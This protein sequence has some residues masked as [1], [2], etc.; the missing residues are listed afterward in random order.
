MIYTYLH[1]NETVVFYAGCG[2]ERRSRNYSKRSLLWKQVAV[3]G[4][5]VLT[6]GEFENRQDAWEHEKELIAY[7]KPHCNKALGGPGSRGVTHSEET[8]RNMSLSKIG[9]LNP[10]SGRTGETNPCYGRQHSA[11]SKLLMSLAKTGK[12]HPQYGKHLPNE[13]KAKISMAHKEKVLSN[14]HKLKISLGVRSY[15]K[16]KFNEN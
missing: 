6:V 1:I 12:N 13:I 9:V 2:N 5:S 3:S 7:F 14:Q 15:Q 10:L 8:R 4:Y 11:E 16:E